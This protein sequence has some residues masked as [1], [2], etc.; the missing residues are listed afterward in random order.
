[1]SHPSPH[2][3]E[4]LCQRPISSDYA[5]PQ[6]VGPETRRNVSG[7][8][9][10]PAGSKALANRVPNGVGVRCPRACR[11]NPPAH[12]AVG[13]PPQG[14][15]RGQVQWGPMYPLAPQNDGPNGTIQRP[16]RYLKTEIR[17]NAGV[18]PGPAT[19]PL[20]FG[21]LGMNFLHHGTKA[22][23]R[24]FS[25]AAIQGACCGRVNSLEMVS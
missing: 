12:P 6:G 1:M 18:A 10:L 17:R 7:S 4:I 5:L 8:D 24:H 21:Q 15:H 16:R 19:A 14:P 2:L 23:G 11:L 3:W 20:P 9:T 13:F 22:L 25:R